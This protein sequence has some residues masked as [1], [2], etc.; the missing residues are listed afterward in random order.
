MIDVVDTV[1]TVDSVY[2][3]HIVD[4]SIFKLTVAL[5]GPGV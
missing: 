1:Y 3:V 4:R 2:T 5:G